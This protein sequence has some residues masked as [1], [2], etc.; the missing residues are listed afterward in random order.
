MQLCKLHLKAIDAERVLARAD[1]DD[2]ELRAQWKD[3]LRRA[4]QELAEERRLGQGL[5][6]DT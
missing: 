4:P 1:A 5:S 2:D 3:I 6:A